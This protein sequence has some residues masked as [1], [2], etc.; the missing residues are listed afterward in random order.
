MLTTNWF[1]LEHY[2]TNRLCES[3]DSS[4]R[5]RRHHAGS[6]YHCQALT[7]VDKSRNHLLLCTSWRSR[8]RYRTGIH[9]DTHLHQYSREYEWTCSYQGMTSDAQSNPWR[10]RTFL[11]RTSVTVWL[12]LALPQRPDIAV[13]PYSASYKTARLGE[14]CLEISLSQ[15]V[16]QQESTVAVS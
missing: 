3:W 13:R 1:Q 4:Q 5:R 10:Q 2:F 15:T 16:L 11:D 12:V 6:C 9:S 8:C 14:K 7:L